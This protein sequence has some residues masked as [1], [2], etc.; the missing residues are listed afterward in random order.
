[1]STITNTSS[2]KYTL[3]FLIQGSWRKIIIDDSLPFN[4]QN[5]L[6]LPATTDPSELWPMLLAK[7]ILK[8]AGTE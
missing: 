5:N 8:L 3:V 4:E 1:M 6:L 7:A 2:H